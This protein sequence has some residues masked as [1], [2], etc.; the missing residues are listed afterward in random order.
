MERHAWNFEKLRNENIQHNFNC[1]VMNQLKDGESWREIKKAILE[2]AKRD[3]TR[4]RRPAK[5]VWMNDE[6]LSLIEKRDRLKKMSSSQQYKALKRDIQQKCRQEK[7]KLVKEEC[8]RLKEL[9]RANNSRE[10]Y[11][12]IKRMNSTPRMNFKSQIMSK[13][14]ETLTTIKEQAARWKEY[15]EEMYSGERISADES[16]G[17]EEEEELTEEEFLRAIESLRNN[18][19]SGSDGIPIELI[20]C[21]CKDQELK[22]R[23]FKLLQNIFQNGELPEDF[24]KSQLIAIP[25]VANTK[26]C[27]EHRTIALT[28]HTMKILLKVVQNR[29]GP[30]LNSSISPWQFGFRPNRGTIEAIAALKTLAAIRIEEEKALFVAFIDFEKAFDRV[31]HSK[32][33]EVL[34]KRGIKGKSLQL[35]KSLYSQQIATFREDPEETKIH[36]HRGVRQGCVLSPIIYNVYADEAFLD[37][38]HGRGIR[39]EDT[40]INRVM[41]ADDTVLIG[42]DKE[43]LKELVSELMERGEE[44]GLKIN[45]KKTK[46]MKISRKG[47]EET[48]LEVKGKRIEAVKKFNYLGVVISNNNKEETE[49]RRR[50]EMAK[51]TFWKNKTLMRG[52]LMIYMKKRIINSC[53]FPVF[54]YAAELWPEKKAIKNSIKSLENWCYRRALKISWMDKVTNEEVKRKMNVERD[55]LLERIRRRRFQYLGHVLRGSAGEELKNLVMVEGTHKVKTRGRKRAKWTQTA[56]EITGERKFANIKEIAEDRDKWKEFLKNANLQW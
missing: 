19:A 26:R 41:Y 28:S 13:A 10:I 38:G 37:F 20:K 12:I 15:I 25:K 23:L 40:H 32:M 35:I 2:T 48:A 39:I 55:V 44:F 27:E 46:I 33:I 49:L 17:I 29:I 5:K 43:E 53:I 3:L 9:S 51:Q 34:K 18:K 14:G 42:S 6:I 30:I 56:K 11:K 1:G 24:V 8:E 21:I 36:I 47:E 16:E 54:C 4:E 7:L 45:C 31:H 52:D 50:I 22:R